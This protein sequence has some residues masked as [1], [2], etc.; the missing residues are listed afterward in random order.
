VAGREEPTP[1]GL[2]RLDVTWRDAEGHAP[3]K[4]FEV[5]VSRDV[6]SALSRLAH[7]R[8]KRNREQLWLVAGDEA[9]AER[10]RR[11]VEPI[12]SGTFAMMRDRARVLSWRELHDLYLKLKPHEGL[13]K[14]LARR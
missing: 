6:V 1:D 10:A 4:A 8:H 13:S 2:F 11:L 5:E 12:L 14:D 3:L 7:A 9:S